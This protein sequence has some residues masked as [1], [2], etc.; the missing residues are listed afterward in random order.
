MKEQDWTFIEELKKPLHQQKPVFWQ[1]R[2]AGDHE[3]SLNEGISVHLDFPDPDYRLDTVWADFA[4][5]CGVMGL[6]SDHES[7]NAVPL[8]VRK[9]ETSCFEAFNL[10]VT[11]QAVYLEAGDTEG[12]RRGM[13]YLEDQ[14]LTAGAPVLPMGITRKEPFIKTRLSRCFF[15]P[16]KR[17]PMNRDELEDQINYYPDE[18]LNKLAHEGVNALWLTITFRDTIPVSSLPGFGRRAAVH[19]PKLRETVARCARY[20]IKVYAFFIEPTAF[21]DERDNVRH[22]DLRLYEK[23]YPQLIGNRQDH[24][25]GFCP[26]SELART[27]LYEA[28]NNLFQAVPGLGGMIDISVGERFTHCS[29][30]WIGQNNCPRC[31]Q[32]QPYE[33]LAEVLDCLNRGMK[34]ANPDAEFISWPYSQYLLWGADGTVEAAGHVPESV[35]LQHN[36]ESSGLVEQLGKTRRADDYWL[37]YTGPSELFRRCAERARDNKTRMFAKLQVG[38]SHEIASVTHVPVPGI[39]FDKYRRMR[40]LGVSGVMQSWY[41]GN[42]PSLMTRAAGRLSFEPFPQE[43]ETFLKQLALPEWGPYSSVVVEA[44]K[45]FQ[46][47]YQQYPVYHV[48]GYYAPVHDGPV[49]PLYLNPV[50]QPLIANWKF[51]PEFP[52]HGDRVGECLQDA[53]SMDE[54][55]LLCSRMHRQWQRGMRLLATIE[56]VFQSDLD[57]SRDINTARA[58]DILFGS[59]LN[60]LRFY[61]LRESMADLTGGQALACLDQMQVLVSREIENST[62]LISCCRI[63]PAL[64]FNSEHEGFRFYPEKL[65]NRI[66]QLEHLLAVEVPELRTRLEQGALPFPAYTGQ[67]PDRQAYICRKA[68]SDENSAVTRSEGDRLSD[69]STAD[70]L[71]DPASWRGVKPEMIYTEDGR[72]A[73]VLRV[74]YQPSWLNIQVVMPGRPAPLALR[75]FPQRLWPEKTWR[76]DPVRGKT[77]LQI[78]DPVRPP[79]I[80][81]TLETS[82]HTEEFGE[83][84]YWPVLLADC[85]DQG[86][87]TGLVTH[88]LFRLSLDELQRPAACRFNPLPF[89]IVLAEQQDPENMKDNVDVDAAKWVYRD[90]IAFRL[91][92]SHVHPDEYGW[93]IFA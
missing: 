91:A 26:S 84:D 51:M 31:S 18:Y 41:F 34:D 46:E 39:L 65:Q 23:D 62:S 68:R 2:A 79:Q 11:L 36:F 7:Q 24:S 83:H 17:P 76:F 78:H 57:R 92:Q 19:L 35:V 90:P 5:F 80:L 87:K 64:G 47:A 4:R 15:G 44:W 21:I 6:S 3:L 52:E 22:L 53:F 74:N 50:N 73:A 71:T 70:L 60:I 30:W 85:Q 86:R 54:A 32:R 89:N 75:F 13:V 40:E 61:Q 69:G 37:S 81:A 29:S 14:I 45:L 42:Y 8:H 16:I 56:P 43:K 28:T 33:V 93:L 25:A 20:G 67:E 59:C 12:I 58:I 66:S 38:C 55:L 88:L 48:F 82:V 1:A 27:F 63:D 72:P 10:T 9:V 77:T 49:W